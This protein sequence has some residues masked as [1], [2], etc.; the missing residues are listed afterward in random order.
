MDKA[1]KGF[2]VLENIMDSGCGR[3]ALLEKLAHDPVDTEI[4]EDHATHTEATRTLL[5][6]LGV[7]GLICGIH[8]VG[9]LTFILFERRICD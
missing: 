9:Y 2:V 5:L 6:L 8:W 1:Y 7:L 4:E 3:S